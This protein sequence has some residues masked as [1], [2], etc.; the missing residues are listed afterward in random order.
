MDGWHEPE[1][2]IAYCLLLCVVSCVWASSLPL[3]QWTK[4]NTI[5]PCAN[6]I[7]LLSLPLSYLTNAAKKSKSLRWQRVIKLLLCAL[8]IL[9]AGDTVVS[10]TRP[11]I[12]II[13][14]RSWFTL[15]MKDLLLF[16]LSLTLLLVLPVT[17]TRVSLILQTYNNDSC[18]MRRKVEKRALLRNNIRNLGGKILGWR[19]ACWAPRT[20]AGEVA[21]ILAPVVQEEQ[22]TWTWPIT[23]SK[24]LGKGLLS[25]ERHKKCL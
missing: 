9:R 5:L 13:F 10:K 4:D 16:L 12:L 7:S 17:E 2:F 3:D 22:G 18:N 1:R 14:Q 25:H 20:E 21:I 8:S 23:W 6:C 15:A 24:G 19:W 11:W